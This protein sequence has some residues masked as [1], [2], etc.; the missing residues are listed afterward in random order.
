MR[1]KKQREHQ[2]TRAKNKKRERWAYETEAPMIVTMKLLG[3]YPE[4]WANGWMTETLARRHTKRL[5]LVAEYQ[6]AVLL[7]SEGGDG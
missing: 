1:T 6:R 2:R 7:V 4:W 5:N 3:G